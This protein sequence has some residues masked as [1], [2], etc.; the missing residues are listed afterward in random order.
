MEH[1]FHLCTLAKE[2][3]LV[4]GIFSMQVDLK[5]EFSY[6]K[7]TDGSEKISLGPGYSLIKVVYCGVCSTDL[8]REHLP[9]PLPQVTGANLYKF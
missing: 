7:F 8:S 4:G 6:N 1:S 3:R 5:I 2:M 9:F